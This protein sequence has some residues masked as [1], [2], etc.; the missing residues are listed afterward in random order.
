MSNPI[1]P[2]CGKEMSES[3]F[4]DYECINGCGGWFYDEP[5]EEV[6]A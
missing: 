5:V 1:C 6:E 4:A 3:E 2:G